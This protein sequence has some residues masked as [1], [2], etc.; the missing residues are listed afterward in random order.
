MKTA[1]CALVLSVGTML[2]GCFDAVPK[3][4]D[5]DV[6]PTLKDIIL[7]KV[8]RQNRQRMQNDPDGLFGQY[9]RDL[10]VSVENIANDS[11]DQESR[12]RECTGDV[13]LDYKS[14]SFRYRTSYTLRTFEDNNRTMATLHDIGPLVEKVGL[15]GYTEWLGHR[16]GGSWSGQ[17]QCGKIRDSN[18]PYQ[19][20]FS[21]PVTMIVSLDE[22]KLA[23]KTKG[24]GDEET[25]GSIDMLDGKVQLIGKGA[26]SADDTWSVVFNGNFEGRHF[27]ATGGIMVS[28]EMGGLLR[29]CSLDLVRQ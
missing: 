11:Y 19:A 2:V 12:R 5:S 25:R 23:R 20:G 7:E 29:D 17:Y 14:S 21:M 3:C 13:V 10:N 4:S 16:Y 22:A 1:K 28:D 18:A 27:K 15:W 6:A 26:N 24:G 9:F 8:E